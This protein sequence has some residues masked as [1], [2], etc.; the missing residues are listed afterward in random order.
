MTTA[1]VSGEFN[2]NLAPI[3]GYAS[4]QNGVNLGRMSIDKT[5]KGSLNATSQG[6]MLSAMTPTQGSAGYVAIEQVIGE[7]DGKK[8][9]FVL[10][11][12]G[13]MDKGQDSLILNVIPDSG[14]NE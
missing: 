12:F 10:Q 9:S 5:F 6:E 14:T 4:G 11:H 1:T 7:L 8:G 13:T 3:E 2:V